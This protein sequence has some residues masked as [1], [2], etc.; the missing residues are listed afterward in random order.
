MNIAIDGRGINLYRGTGIG[1]YTENLI[2]NLLYLDHENKYNIYWCGN[3]SEEFHKDNFNLTMASQKHH[4]F[5]EQNYFPAHIKRENTDIYHVPQNGLGLKPLEGCKSLVTIH[6]LIPYITPETVGK[7]YLNK[8]LKDMPS[9]ME[10]SDGIITVSQWS[11]KDILKFFP[12]NEDKIFVTPLAANEKFKVLSKEYCKKILLT[13]YNINK[14]FI[15]Y[16]GGFSLRKN[17][18]TLIDAFIRSFYNF[19]KNYMLVLP[20]SIKDEGQKLVDYVSA[21]PLKDNIKFFGF[22]D[23]DMLPILYNGCSLFVYPSLYEG[24]GLPPLEAMCCGAPVLSS[25]LTSIPEVI[26][27]G[28]ITV[29][30]TIDNLSTSMETI[31]NDDFLQIN[32]SNAALSRAKNFSWEN[33]AN[34][35]L[36]VYKT[37]HELS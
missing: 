35:T 24:F 9:I 25:N 15:L 27:N 23:E 4:R 22:C 28:G 30:P 11:K 21:T 16:V 37:L 5:F 18:R 13:K 10:N 36:D 7:G 14:D 1:T 17:V 2:K 20:G 29:D 33:T 12:I 32:L 6:D 8:F 26:G 31:L 19:N 3:Y 34:L